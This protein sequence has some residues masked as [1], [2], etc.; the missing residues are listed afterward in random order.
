MDVISHIP[1]LCEDQ[2]VP[3]VFV[4]SKAELGTSAATKRPTSC[5]LVSPAAA[6]KGAKAEFEA[7]DKLEECV[8]EV[9]QLQKELE[10]R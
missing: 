4:S 8:V 1:V 7:A 2:D 3:Y 10:A 9:K 5:V 6:G